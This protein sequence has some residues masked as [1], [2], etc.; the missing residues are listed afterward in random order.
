MTAVSAFNPVHSWTRLT[1]GVADDRLHVCLRFG[2]SAIQR[3]RNSVTHHWFAPGQV[4][5]VTWWAR[6]SPRKQ[7][8]CFAVVE[9]LHIG[10]AGYRLPCIR[11]AVRVHLFVNTR[12]IGRDRR[13]VDR[14]EELIGQIEQAGLD[15]QAVAPAYYSAAGQSLRIG[16]TPRALTAAPQRS[17]PHA[18]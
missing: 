7:F 2:K 10:D 15:P 5:A 13:C 17:V 8:A 14:A 18:S 4:L 16:R 6:H 1:T 9:T 12:C 3:Q 11:P